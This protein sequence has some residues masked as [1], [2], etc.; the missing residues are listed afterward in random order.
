MLIVGDN[1]I[2]YLECVAPKK[3]QW[4]KLYAFHSLDYV[5]IITYQY[6]Y[7]YL[8]L[9]QVLLLAAHGRIN[10]AS[11]ELSR[12]ECVDYSWPSCKNTIWEKN[13]SRHFIFK[14]ISLHV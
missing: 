2:S 13:I 9:V 8:L 11:R 4:I 14:A 1:N 7:Y 10:Q 3:I 6:Y 12:G 5:D